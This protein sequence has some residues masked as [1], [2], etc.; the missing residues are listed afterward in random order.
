MSDDENKAI[1]RRV[2]EV[3]DQGNEV[4][5]A[6]QHPGLYETGQR[7]AL[8]RAAFRTCGLR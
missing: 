1:V 3:L 6:E 5:A 8:L 4:A 7:H 2:I